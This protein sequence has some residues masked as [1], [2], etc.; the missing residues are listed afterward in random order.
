M[1]RSLR[2]IPLL[3]ALVAPTT[4]AQ[5]GPGKL[6]LNSHEV[7]SDGSITFH[8]LNAGAKEVA[9]GL[10]IYAK[11]LA[12]TH[13]DGDVWSVTTPPLPPE[14]YGYNF[15]VDGVEQMDPLNNNVNFNYA[16][17][18]NKVLVPG[19]TPMPWEL[20]SIPHGRT[21][22]HVFTSH[23]AKNLPEDQSAYVVY[24]PPGYDAKKSGGYPVLY[25]LHGWSDIEIAWD[26][27]AHAN[28]ILDSLIHSGKAVPMIVVMPLGYGDL[29]FVQ[30]GWGVW[31]QPAKVIENTA[32]FS[33]ELLTEVMPAVNS[34][35]NTAKGR[36]NTAIAGLSMGGLES[37]ST[38]LNNLQ[39]F[40]WVVGM[41]SA[42]IG[43]DFDKM[44]PGIQTASAPKPRLL[45]VACGT[46]DRLIT[47]N[48][49]FVA[50]AK[51]KNLNPV[52]V[53][54]PGL[55]TWEVWRD[56]LVHVA[57]LLFKK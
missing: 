27:V 17:L 30:D 51:E 3:A 40:G 31:Q 35:Y 45:W 57:P 25:L 12:M 39:T 46:E 28:Y 29:R 42:I 48:R 16:F 32:L 22:H 21:D 36:D 24:T 34:E 54:T 5:S 56:N 37:L 47:A 7:H 4:F 9:V 13:G 14:I 18:G 6:P 1:L 8:Y 55:H 49:A 26:E 41:S 11:P 33:Q 43:G 15:T 44:L 50:W 53:E 19:P 10:D 20:T 52:A 38:G 23:V 2:L